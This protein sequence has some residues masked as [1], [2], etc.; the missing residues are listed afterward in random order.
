MF[1]EPQYLDD[2]QEAYE[3]PPVPRTICYGA[4]SAL[5]EH[6]YCKSTQET[7]DLRCTNP[8]EERIGLASRNGSAFQQ[9]LWTRPPGTSVLLLQRI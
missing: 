5:V 4:V 1:D 9:Y 2:V 3:L 6:K 8:S 7:I